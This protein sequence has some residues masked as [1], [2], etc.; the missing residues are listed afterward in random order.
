MWHFTDPD[1]DRVAIWLCIMCMFDSE[2]FK[3]GNCLRV[4]TNQAQYTSNKHSATAGANQQHC[5]LGMLKTVKIHSCRTKTRQYDYRISSQNDCNNMGP[6]SFQISTVIFFYCNP[7]DLTY[8]HQNYIPILRKYDPSGKIL[9]DKLESLENVKGQNPYSQ[10]K[11][12]PWTI[13]NGLEIYMYFFCSS[14]VQ[15]KLKSKI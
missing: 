4:T 1:Y 10:V 6:I 13:C 3:D 12:N 14:N 15:T 11:R 9:G 8:F 2:C 5:V 7:A